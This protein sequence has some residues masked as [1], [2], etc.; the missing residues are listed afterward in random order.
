MSRHEK[1]PSQSFEPTSEE[2]TGP[3]G[4]FSSMPTMPLRDHG[5][6]RV[7][8]IIS[9]NATSRKREHSSGEQKLMENI[10]HSV[11]IKQKTASL[12]A[13]YQRNISMQWGI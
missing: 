10:E 3:D 8:S 2:F 6:E 4:Y 7:V 9:W 13:Y 12:V 1:S 11:V 5:V